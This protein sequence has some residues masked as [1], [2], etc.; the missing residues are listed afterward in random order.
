MDRFRLV[1]ACAVF[2]LGTV[3]MQAQDSD[4]LYL[5]RSMLLQNQNI[6]YENRPFSSR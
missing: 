2:I 6:F 1:F 4:S 3:T 5:K